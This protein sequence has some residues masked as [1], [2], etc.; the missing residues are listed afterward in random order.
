M[1]T[2]RVYKRLM[3]AMVVVIS[4]GMVSCVDN[5]DNSTTPSDK[6]QQ[7]DNDEDDF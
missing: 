6:E 4:L 5:I 2:K 7:E 3:A 1:I